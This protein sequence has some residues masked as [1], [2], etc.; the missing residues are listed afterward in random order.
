MVNFSDIEAAVQRIKDAVNHTPI[1]SS[2]NLNSMYDA[3]F[4]FK[5]ENF[6]RIGAFKFRGA[7]NACLQLTE[8]QKKKGVITHSSGNH[9]Q[10][11]ALAAKMLNIN[12]TVVMP[13]GSPEVKINATRDTYGAKVVFCENSIKARHDTTQ[14]LIDEFGY[15]MIHPYDNDQIIA[16]AGTAA[17]ELLK[18]KPDLDYIIAPVGGGGLLS[19]TAL[20]S[21]GLNPNIK[22]FAAEPLLVDDAFRSIQSGKIETNAQ[23]N[24]IADGLRTNLAERTFNIIQKNVDAIIRVNEYQIID[25]MR[26]LWERMKL[27]V[28][29]SGAVPLAAV[30]SGQMDIK[31]KKVGLIIS[32]GNVDVGEFFQKLRENVV[33]T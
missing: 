33:N 6:Q 23:I 25:A 2:R 31:D 8:D 30:M 3:E 32:G 28:E 14:K 29:P 11:L 13:L 12:A 26:F 1:M 17:Y 24:T 5:C 20:A 4:Y 9:A 22:V 15:T 16:G 19:G 7:M 18:E 27:V 21:K 10:A